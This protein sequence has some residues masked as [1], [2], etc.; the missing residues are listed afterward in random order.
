MDYLPYYDLFLLPSYSEGCPLALLEAMAA[1]KKT[2]CSD[3]SV[4]KELFDDS[5]IEFFNIKEPS[6]LVEAIQRALAL[7]DVEKKLKKHFA[8]KFSSEVIY[9]RLI[10]IYNK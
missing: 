5:G 7:S 3:I 6:S 4:H 10:E 1:G 9:S 8:E 2:V